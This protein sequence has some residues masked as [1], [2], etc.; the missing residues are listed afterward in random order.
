MMQAQAGKK[1]NKVKVTNTTI[2]TDIYSMVA[3]IAKTLR[4]DAFGAA[5]T[6]GA[7]AATG[8]GAR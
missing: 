8:W 5:A 7:A 1:Q 2:D 3:S 4:Y 6:R